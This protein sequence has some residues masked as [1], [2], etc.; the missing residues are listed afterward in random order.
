MDET[1]SAVSVDIFDAIAQQVATDLLD[2]DM[3]LERFAVKYGT[4]T[5][6]AKKALN[7][8][9]RDGTL[10]KQRRLYKGLVVAAYIPE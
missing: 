3:T 9:V 4:T 2:T 1:K 5:R 10:K 7:K 8:A 6:E